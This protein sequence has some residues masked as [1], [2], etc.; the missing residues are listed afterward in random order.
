MVNTSI[1]SNRDPRFTSLFSGGVQKA[2][3]TRLDFNT[4]FH[5]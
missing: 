2:L 4:N 3:G 1:V 5:P